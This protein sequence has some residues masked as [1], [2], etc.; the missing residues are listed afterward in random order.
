MYGGM[1]KDDGFVLQVH[2]FFQVTPLGNINIYQILSAYNCTFYSFV[3][4]LPAMSC[5]SN[6][7]SLICVGLRRWMYH[8]RGAVEE[9]VPNGPT[10]PQAAEIRS[11][12]L[13]WFWELY[14]LCCLLMY[15]SFSVLC[16]LYQR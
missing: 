7:T 4:T 12:L 5:F 6:I 13:D 2:T 1:E 11:L 14:A 8:M 10:I 15:F 16:F 9:T 3:N